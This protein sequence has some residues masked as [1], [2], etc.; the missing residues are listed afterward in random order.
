MSWLT[1]PGHLLVSDLDGTLLR[2]DTS[3]SDAARDGL[4]ALVVAGVAVTVASARSTASMRPM[5][6]GVDLRLPVIEHNGAYISDLRTGEHLVANAMDAATAGKA[7]E[8]LGDPIVTSWDGARDRVHHGIDLNAGAAWFI[9]EKRRYADPRLTETADLRAVADR[10]Q[11]VMI[12]SFVPDEQAAGVVTAVQAAVGEDARVWA[13]LNAYSPGWSEVVV[14]SPLATKGAAILELRRRL[15]LAG[16]ITVC[17]DHVNDLPMFAVADRRVAP[18]NARPEVRAA[19]SV[20]TGANDDDGVVTYLLGQLAIR[21]R[22]AH[23]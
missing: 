6:P 23:E 13:A 19:A 1:A 17:G 12:C 18:A 21:R 22:E 2:S 20:V 11:V 10:E 3:L 16:E 14:Q 15:G 9:T 8:L 7:I 5:L 4:N